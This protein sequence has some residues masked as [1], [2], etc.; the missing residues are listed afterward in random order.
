MIFIY[1]AA[2]GPGNG[3]L[4]SLHKIFS[5]GTY[6][7]S[8]CKLTYGITGEKKSWKHFRKSSGLE[9]EF[10]HADE[11][12]KQYASK[13]GYKFDYPIVLTES[14]EGL[15][16]LISTVELNKLKDDVELKE[17]ITARA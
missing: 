11:F 16:V 7:C 12:R 5:P 13:F 15:Q 1:N 14:D 8:L 6:S 4:D 9:M 10:L 2:S 17:L 3:V